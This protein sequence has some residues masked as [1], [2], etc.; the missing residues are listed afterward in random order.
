MNMMS[1]FSR[2]KNVLLVVA[3]IA[4]GFFVYNVFFMNNGPRGAL[5]SETID[6][7]QAAV[8]QELIGLLAQLRSIQLDLSVFDNREFQSLIDF[9]QEL[10]PE[11]IGRE[12][13][14]APL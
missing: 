7:V 6:P 5:V 11:P 1:L 10:I 8:E 3:V 13:P 12:N 9:G 14:F 4:V 2:Y